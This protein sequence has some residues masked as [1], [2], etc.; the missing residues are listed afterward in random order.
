MTETSSNLANHYVLSGRHE[1]GWLQE[2]QDFLVKF[3]VLGQNN[4]LTLI[5]R[6]SSCQPGLPKPEEVFF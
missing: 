6:P 1:N 2:L 5:S 3:L 4:K